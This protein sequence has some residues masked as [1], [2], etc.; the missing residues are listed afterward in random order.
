MYF[1]EIFELG[2]EGEDPLFDLRH[3]FY[4]ESVDPH[5]CTLS[6]AASVAEVLNCVTQ[7]EQPTSQHLTQVLLEYTRVSQ[8]IYPTLNGVLII[9]I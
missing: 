2:I 3:Y 9:K 5:L 4:P 6:H 8:K 7:L 1:E